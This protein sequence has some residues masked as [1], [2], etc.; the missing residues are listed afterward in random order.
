MDGL[1]KIGVDLDATISAY[2]NF[3]SVFT[4]AMA[5]AGC[6]IYII[7]DRL[8]GTEEMVVEELAS[9][10]ITYHELMITR[11]KAHYIAEEGIEVL[12]DDKDEYFVDLPDSIAVFKV[13][14]HYN[15]DFHQKKW[16]YSKRTGRKI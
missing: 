13:R 12:F 7:T 15:F 2:P 6:R 8:P 1:M 4:K 10:G 16:L 3:F 5:K 9:Y 14:E 11:D